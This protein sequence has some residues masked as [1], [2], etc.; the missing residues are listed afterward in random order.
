MENFSRPNSGRVSRIKFKLGTGIDH[1]VA[2]RDMTPRLKGQR[3]RSQRHVTYPGKNCNNS[4]LGSRIKF[5][6]GS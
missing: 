6:F 1:Q 4:V 3:S 5:T 2:L